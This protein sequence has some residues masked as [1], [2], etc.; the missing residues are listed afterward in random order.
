MNVREP[1]ILF[2][3]VGKMGRPMAQR[4][5][6][7]G[8]PLT[9]AD[10]APAALAAFARDVPA[11]AA[12]AELAGEL[13]ITML[14][15][16]HHV[17]EALFGAGGALE[18][19]RAAV[20]DM[21]SSAPAGS[22]RIAE[23]LR[24]RGIAFLDAPVSGGVPG[25]TNGTLTSMIGGDAALLEAYRP[26]LEAMCKT[27][28][29]VGDVTAGVTMKALNN[30]LSAVALWAT[31]EALVVGAKSGLDPQTMVDVWR[32]SSGTSHAV[33][34]KV[35]AAVLPRTFDYGFSVGLMA[36]DL[37][38]AAGIA[39]DADV[40]APLIAEHAATWA[41][42]RDAL[43]FDRDVT[44]VITLVEQWSNYEVPRT[45]SPSSRA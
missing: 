36:K 39:R 34:V 37:G 18:R 4:L 45:H 10:T 8:F 23:R 40:S 2:V 33:Q 41:L 7:A 11:S 22:R 12:P 6:A 44:A 16:D 27:L 15:T 20:I 29:H 17:A 21:S 32:T 19:P 28:V 31:S 42:A 43:G 14:P 9:I 5:H 13:V 1:S 3:G 38:I 26:V 30:F 25:A 24:E 35:P